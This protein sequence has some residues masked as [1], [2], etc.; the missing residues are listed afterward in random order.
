M[1]EDYHRAGP[2][3]KGPGMVFHNPREVRR[4]RGRWG[5]RIRQGGK[6]VDATAFRWT[7]QNSSIAGPSSAGGAPCPAPTPATSSWTWRWE[8]IT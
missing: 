2:R 7:R 6:T 3:D 1:A 8:A 4:I 5:P